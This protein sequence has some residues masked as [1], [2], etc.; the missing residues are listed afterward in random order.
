MKLSKFA[1]HMFHM[2][3]A[4][5]HSCILVHCSLLFVVYSFGCCFA[6][7]TASGGLLFGEA[8]NPRKRNPSYR[9]ALVSNRCARMSHSFIGHVSLRLQSHS[10]AND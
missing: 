4:M 10:V 7:Y 8:I 6:F 5:D 1:K 9:C 2:K 3:I